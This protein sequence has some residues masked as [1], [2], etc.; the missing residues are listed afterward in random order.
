MDRATVD[1]ERRRADDAERDGVLDVG[2]DLRAVLAAIEVGIESDHVEPEL[3]RDQIDRRAI[4]PTGDRVQAI[5]H[6]LESPLR[7]GSEHGLGRNRVV[8]VERQ[9][10]VHPA[11]LPGVQA[12]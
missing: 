8:V 3:A 4:D 11:Q 12:R 1:E 6:R 2:V 9:R 7:V 10:A 5:R